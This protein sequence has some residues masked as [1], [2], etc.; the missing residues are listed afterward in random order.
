MKPQR[1][2]YWIATL[3]VCSVFI[4]SAQMYF[5]NT[6]MVKIYFEHLHYPSYVVIPLA[7]A[8]L[9]AVILILW[10]GIAWVTE[11]AY[12]GLF[13]DALL[14]ITAHMSS[15]DKGY[16]LSLIALITILISYFLGK[17]VRPMYE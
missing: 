1:I 5:R 2:L 8:K 10:R 12:A 14:A 15:N 7:V 11:W 13:F 9:V 3:L 6:E 4:Y 17:K 16:M